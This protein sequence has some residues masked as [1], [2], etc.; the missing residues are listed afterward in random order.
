MDSVVRDNEIKLSCFSGKDDVRCRL[1]PKFA[2]VIYFGKQ[3]FLSGT[4]R[5]DLNSESFSRHPFDEL[6]KCCYEA[7]C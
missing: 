1:V 2:Q 4:V 7:F 3:W 5:E 6:Q